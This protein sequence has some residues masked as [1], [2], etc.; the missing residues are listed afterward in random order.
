[1]VLNKRMGKT[2]K[3]DEKNRSGPE[4]KLIS[5]H[6]LEFEE[7]VDILVKGKPKKNSQEEEEFSQRVVTEEEDKTANEGRVTKS[8]KKNSRGGGDGIG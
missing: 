2:T 7:V 4:P 5:L 6:P 1:M 3:K 8:C